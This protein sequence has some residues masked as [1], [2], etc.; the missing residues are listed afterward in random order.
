[1]KFTWKMA[2][3]VGFLLA[4]IPAAHPQ[5]R[6]SGLAQLS[7]VCGTE[8][9]TGWRQI[10][11]FNG[12]KWR[13][14]GALTEIPERAGEAT[15]LAQL[16]Q[17]P[18]NMILVAIS[19]DSR[20]NFAQTTYC[21]GRSGQLIALAHEVRNPAGWTFLVS[22][23]YDD[24]GRAQKRSARC[25][26]RNTGHDLT[27]SKQRTLDPGL[28]DPTVYSRFEDLPFAKLYRPLSD[29]EKY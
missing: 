15:R 29:F 8:S 11:A 22:Q 16:W 1:M 13:R 26:D 9:R 2:P 3:F 27:R 17:G 14:Y 12:M 5:S 24:S 20:N 7:T 6:P 18:S 4:L 21:F 28:L 10:F 19:S 23:E 25:F